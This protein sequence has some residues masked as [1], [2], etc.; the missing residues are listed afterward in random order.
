M[1]NAQYWCWLQRTLGTK[2]K[3]EDAAAYFGDAKEIYFAG[4]NEL[5]LSG[6]LTPLQVER[7]IAGRESKDLMLGADKI[8]NRCSKD[9]ICV[10]TPE[11]EAYPKALLTL[12]DFPA[13]L[14]SRG[15]IGLLNTNAEIAVVGTR[16][17]S[18]NSIRITE[19]LSFEI[20][21][22]GAIVVSGGARGID[23][24]AH[25][26][27]LKAGG[28]TAAVLGCGFGVNYLPE[29]NELREKIA[30]NGVLITE[31]P[32]G[33]EGSKFTFP[34]R[35]R[36]ISGLSLGT[37]IIEASSKSGSLITAE[38]ALSQGRDVFAV[39]GDIINSAYSGANNLIRDGAKPV[40]CAYDVLEEYTGLYPNLIHINPPDEK[41]VFNTDDE[42]I[43]PA[44]RIFSTEAHKKKDPGK[45]LSAA[46]K[47]IYSLF[48]TE[49]LSIPEMSGRTEYGMNVILGAL[50][51]LE[52]Y[53]YIEL[54]SSRTYRIK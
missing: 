29:N 49:P 6:T 19:R 48:G 5:R 23:S 54:V 44:A 34:Q 25:R 14:F 2:A 17:P 16:K 50:T 45:E 47:D 13:V 33:T 15:N 1:K 20:A 39:P 18:S 12:P 37:L 9:G 21:R 46:A 27:A 40:F 24:S 53:A 32:P 11:D 10:S 51:E 3:I 8:L 38:Y 41:E 26:G 28:Q 30:E 22:A 36:I 4:N 35:N 31:Y 42:N 43:L 7:L 52:M